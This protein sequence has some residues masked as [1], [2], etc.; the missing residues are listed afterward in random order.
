MRFIHEAVGC[1]IISCLLFVAFLIARGPLHLG[2][3]P[4]VYHCPA[5]HTLVTRWEKGTAAAGQPGTLTY[6]GWTEWASCSQ[7][8]TIDGG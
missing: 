6:H 4:L 3:P 2:A 7:S 8:M 1:L 5:G